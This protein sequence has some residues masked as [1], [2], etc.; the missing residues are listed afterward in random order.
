MLQHNEKRAVSCEELI[1]KRFDW[2]HR[3]VAQEEKL[4][5][6]TLRKEL[7]EKTLSIQLQQ[8][9]IDAKLSSLSHRIKC[10]EQQLQSQSSAPLTEIRAPLVPPT[11]DPPA[12][13]P[14]GLLI[15]EARALGNLDYRVWQNMGADITYSPV[16][17]DPNT[18]H[19]YLH[20]SEDLTSVRR[21]DIKQKVPLNPERFLSYTSVLG[22]EG[23]SSGTHRWDVEVGDHPEWVIGLVKESMDRRSKCIALPENGYWCLKQLKNKYMDITD[24]TVTL[25]TRPDRIQVELDYE[26]GRVS[27]FDAKDMTLICSHTDTFTEK[28]FPYFS[29]GPAGGATSTKDIKIGPCQVNREESKKRPLKEIWHLFP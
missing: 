15:D 24:N 21:E 19:R 12:P 8:K 7:E 22:S 18:A 1:S 27:F 6:S 20:L 9:D 23:F 25:S 2:L 29:L 17:L 28:L 3:I 5:V 11:R 13:E 16:V 4:C 10:A 14:A 26:A